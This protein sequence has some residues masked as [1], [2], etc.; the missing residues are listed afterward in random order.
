MNKITDPIQPVSEQTANELSEQMRKLAETIPFQH[1]ILKDVY[2]TMIKSAYKSMLINSA[3]LRAMSCIYEYR[4]ECSFRIT[5]WYWKRKLD[6]TN[7]QLE[8][9]EHDI[10]V[11]EEECSEILT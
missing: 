11:L 10:K 6:K 8:K 1:E 3:T 9:V 2:A 7:E 4:L 5:R